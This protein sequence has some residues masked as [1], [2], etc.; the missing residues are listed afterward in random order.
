MESVKQGLAYIDYAERFSAQEI[1]DAIRNLKTNKAA[2]ADKLN[3][4]HF[5]YCSKRL[6]PIL[7]MIYNCSLIHG[8][9]P[10]RLMESIIV[11]IAKDNKE[12][13]TN[14]DNYRPIALT[15]VGSKLLE[16]VML[17]R[18]RN[19][20]LSTE[21][22]FG[23]KPKHSTDM[24][25]FALK[26]TVQFY[27]SLGSPVYL[28]FMDASKAFDKVNHWHLYDKLL[29]RNVP[30]FIVRL[31]CFWFSS[32]EFMV[33]WDNMF[34]TS[35]KVCNGVR[36]GG[37]LSPVLFNVYIDDLSVRL[38]SS[39]IGCHFYSTCVNHFFYADDAVLLA[40][41]PYALKCL[42]DI[43]VQ[44]ASENE[45]MY[46]TTKT[47]CMFIRGKHCNDIQPVRQYLYGCKLRWV[48]T[49]CYLGCFITNDMK[50]ERDIK[51]QTRSIYGRGNVT[52]RKFSNCSAEVKNQL[53]R[54]YISCLYS[55][56]LWC[57]YGT[58][59]YSA[60][61]VAYNNVYRNLM[62]IIPGSSIT[63]AYVRNYVSDFNVTR[64]KFINNFR[65]ILMKS[66]NKI[67]SSFISS[68]YFMYSSKLNCKWYKATYVIG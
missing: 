12:P 36:Q 67:V 9:L 60:V 20:L 43:C 31:L 6:Y 28:C 30:L 21:A 46:N 19:C 68:V 23:Y 52:V 44:F 66:C 8:Y 51:R 15:C 63:S 17:E 64:R 16:T 54:S 2:G 38:N 13:L 50:D 57:S 48:D 11:P 39:N 40:P 27:I 1:A 58:K 5:I 7:C 56:H 37:I 61:R 47:K 33:K 4:E 32:Q 14:K 41:S 49:I 22:Q 62:G 42:I 45:M 24:C 3:S 55:S 53:F 35:F 34:S 18:Y 26:E 10:A 25:V 59:Q 29:K 65:S